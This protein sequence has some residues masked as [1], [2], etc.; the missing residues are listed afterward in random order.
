MNNKATKGFFCTNLVFLHMLFLE[1]E[2]QFNKNNYRK[3]FFMSRVSLPKLKE[4]LNVLLVKLVVHV[5]MHN[6]KKAYVPFER[7]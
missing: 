2:A 5:Q 3:M 6:Q 7:T 1:N 4:H